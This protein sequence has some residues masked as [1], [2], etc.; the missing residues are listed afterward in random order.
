VYVLVEAGRSIY[1]RDGVTF[2]AI[3]EALEQPGSVQVSH[4]RVVTSTGGRRKIGQK[5]EDRPKY[6]TTVAAQ[7]ERCEMRFKCKL[8]LVLKDTTIKLHGDA[9]I[10]EESTSSMI[11]VG[12]REALYGM[13]ARKIRFED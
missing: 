6:N 1:L 11:A 4:G 2:A 12:G 10:S 5:H 7:V 13:S 3:Q 8:S 9:V